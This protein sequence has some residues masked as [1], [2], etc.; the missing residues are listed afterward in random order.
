STLLEQPIGFQYPRFFLTASRL[1]VDVSQ[2]L[3]SLNCVPVFSTISIAWSGVC[4][5]NV[6]SIS[7]SRMLN[8]LFT[9]ESVFSSPDCVS[10]GRAG[11]KR[12]SWF[13]LL[14]HQHITLGGC[15]HV[16]SMRPAA[17]H[18]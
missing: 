4:C 16:M 10:F 13:R 12:Y 17:L 3:C 11:Q 2:G 14:Q 15:L 5:A 9:N 18:A 1:C 8:N 6:F 7:I